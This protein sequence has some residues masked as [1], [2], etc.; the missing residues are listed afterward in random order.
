MK[1]QKK[2]VTEGYLLIFGLSRRNTKI[3]FEIWQLIY[4]YGKNL[5]IAHKFRC[6]WIVAQFVLP[7]DFRY[8]DRK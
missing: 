7:A 2:S 3:P 5:P 1:C 8:A 4:E 6:N